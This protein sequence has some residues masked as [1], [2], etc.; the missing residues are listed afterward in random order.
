MY[1]NNFFF[2]YVFKHIKHGAESISCMSQVAGYRNK[3][4]FMEPETLG[5]RHVIKQWRGSFLRLVL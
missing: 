5:L 1:I 2:H 3:S 4:S